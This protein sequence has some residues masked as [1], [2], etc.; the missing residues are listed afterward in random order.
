MALVSSLF[1]ITGFVHQ[2]VTGTKAIYQDGKP[3]QYN[4]IETIATKMEEFHRHIAQSIGKHSITSIDQ[5]AIDIAM[6]CQDVVTELI[7]VLDSM[8]RKRKTVWASFRAALSAALKK[9][10]VDR[11]CSDVFNLQRT[12]ATYLQSRL[13]SAISFQYLPS[14][15]QPHS[16][17][18]QRWPLKASYRF[19][20]NLVMVDQTTRSSNRCF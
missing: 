19:D 11:L 17:P 18:E 2:L 6:T 8:E 14:Q 20:A 1:Q 15:T 12:L 13:L 4:T 3:G 10:E 9:A 5:A 16:H 7:D